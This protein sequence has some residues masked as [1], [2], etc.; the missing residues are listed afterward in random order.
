[1]VYRS[2]D[3]KYYIGDRR[4][5]FK[6]NITDEAYQNVSLNNKKF[7]ALEN[8]DKKFSYFL[9]SQTRLFRLLDF[10]NTN[11][12]GNVKL[13]GRVFNLSNFNKDQKLLKKEFF[14][15]DMKNIDKSIG[16]LYGDVILEFIIMDSSVNIQDLI[17]YCRLV[18]CK[19]DI[20]TLFDI[21]DNDKYLSAYN[22]NK[23]SIPNY[24]KN[25]IKEEETEDEQ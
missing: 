20:Y 12:N 25:M 8:I 21:E 14:V 13:F 23:I 11:K 4:N 10:I 3:N 2:E 5:F 6:L 19:Y 18:K 1:M 9:E 7:K 16:K 15:L 17:D 22:I 24:I